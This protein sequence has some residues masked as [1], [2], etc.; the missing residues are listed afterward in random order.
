M[1]N[2]LEFKVIELDRQLTD[3]AYEKL[4][5]GELSRDAFVEITGR[6]RLWSKMGYDIVGKLDSRAQPGG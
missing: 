5:D 1:E 3:T 2:S 6:L 4:T